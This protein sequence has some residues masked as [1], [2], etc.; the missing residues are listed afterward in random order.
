MDSLKS[1]SIKI[2][3]GPSCLIVRLSDTNASNTTEASVVEQLTGVLESH[4]VNRVVV[5]SNHY[6]E[7]LLGDLDALRNKVKSQGGSVKLVHRAAGTPPAPK[8]LSNRI[9]SQVPVYGNLEAAFL[10]HRFENRE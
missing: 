3:R 1:P 2:E 8:R 6:S 10:V 4:S 7:Q 5:E 9:K